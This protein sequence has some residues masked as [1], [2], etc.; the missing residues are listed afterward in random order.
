MTRTGDA[1]LGVCFAIALR[2]SAAESLTT[3]HAAPNLA[4]VFSWVEIHPDNSATIRVPQT[5][6]GQG[7]STTIPQIVADELRLDWARV[8]FQFYDPAHNARHDN[9]YVWTTS[10]GSSSAHY[11][12]GPARIAAAQIRTMLLHAGV[13]DQL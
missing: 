9:V 7:V 13:G 3:S 5:E 8:N 4:R 10:L 2:N 12:F 6:M 1:A 11:L